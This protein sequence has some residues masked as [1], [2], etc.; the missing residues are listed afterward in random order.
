MLLPVSV[1]DLCPSL[2]PLVHIQ[3]VVGFRGNAIGHEHLAGFGRLRA[4]PE[5]E[6]AYGAVDVGDAD[7]L[8][9]LSLGMLAH[10]EFGTH[11]Q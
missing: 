6:Q 10:S 4:R 1:V 11:E 8:G 7:G 5:H 9:E 2:A 3:D